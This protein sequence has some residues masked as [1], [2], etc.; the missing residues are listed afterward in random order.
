[1]PR[2]PRSNERPGTHGMSG[3]RDKKSAMI[4]EHLLCPVPICSGRSQQSAAIGIPAKQGVT[5]RQQVWHLPQ[6]CLHGPVFPAAA[7]APRW[8]LNCRARRWLTMI[9]ALHQS[10]AVPLAAHLHSH[11]FQDSDDWS[12]GPQQ[13]YTMQQR[14]AETNRRDGR[15]SRGRELSPHGYKSW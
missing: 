15:D 1:M 13:R 8:Q 9:G 3:R 7:H 4:L 2:P 12:S 14:R 5:V 11:P 6:N 10:S